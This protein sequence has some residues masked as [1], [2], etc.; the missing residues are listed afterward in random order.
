MI[1][2]T[3]CIFG[4]VAAFTAVFA[5]G[6]LEA[7]FVKAFNEGKPLTAERAFRQLTEKKAKLAPIRYW[8]AAEVARQTRKASLRRDRL[9]RFL[10]LEKTWTKETEQAAWELCVASADAREFARLAKNVPASPLLYRAGKLLLSRFR[11]EKRTSDFMSVAGTLLEKFTEKNKRLSV[12]GDLYHFKW[13]NAPGYSLK[14]S[15]DLLLKYPE[16]AGGEPVNTFINWRGKELDAKWIVDYS[17]KYKVRLPFNYI[18]NSMIPRLGEVKDAELRKKLIKDFIALEN[19]YLKGGE[20][21]DSLYLHSAEWFGC[22]Y[23]RYARY[24]GDG[25]SATAEQSKANVEFIKRFVKA[26]PATDA[27]R[28]VCQRVIGE[29]IAYKAVFPVDIVAYSRENPKVFSAVDLYN[30][31]GVLAE[32]S[33]QKSIKPLKDLLARADNRYPVRWNTLYLLAEYGET[34]IVKSTLEESISNDVLAPDVGAIFSSAVRCK[35]LSD[36]QKVEMVAGLYKL[37]GHGKRWEFLIGKGAEKAKKDYKFL[38]TPEGNAFLAT[39]K[40]TVVSS[41]PIYAALVKIA[42][43][44]QASGGVCPGE[45]HKVVADAIKAYIALADKAKSRTS[46][47]HAILYRYYTLCQREPNSA[48]KYIEVTKDIYGNGYGYWDGLNHMCGLAMRNAKNE[49]IVWAI[50]EKRA[51]VTGDYSPLLGCN[52]PSSIGALPKDI[53]YF[54]ANFD[55]FASFITRQFDY[56]RIKSEKDML[57]ALNLL[58]KHPGFR[59]PGDWLID[60]VSRHFSSR[61]SKPEVVKAFPWNEALA[62]IVDADVA[63]SGRAARVMLNMFAAVGRGDE[64]LKTYLAAANKLDSVPKAS[65]IF[66]LVGM[67]QIITFP[68]DK[69]AV[70]A[71]VKDRMGPFLRE[72]VIPALSAIKSN[73]FPLVDLG[74]AQSWDALCNYGNANRENKEVQK[75]LL[76]TYRQGVKL[77]NGNC[78][79]APPDSVYHCIAY[80]NVYAE[81]LA[82][83]NT[84]KM[85]EC[86]AT[87]G[88]TVWHWNYGAF[89]NLLAKTRDAGFWESAYLMAN[90]VPADRDSSTVAF[91]SRV[92]AEAAPK[93]PGIYPVDEKNPAYPLY[94]AAD[95]LSRKNSERAWELLKK[96]VAVFEREAINL[97][98]DFTA[99]GVEQLRLDRGAKDENLIKARQIAT[100]I[101]GNEARVIADLAAAMLLVRAECFR[102]Q[103]NFEAA[104]LEYQSIRNNPK[105]NTTPAGRKAM[106]R[107][108]DLMIETGN[109]S[110][111]EATIEYWLSQPDTEIQAQA[112]YFAAR[113]AFDRKD[114]DETIKELREVFAI[115][116]THTDARFLQGK[117]KLATNSEVDDTDVMIG[118]LSDRTAIRPGQ[119]LTITVQDRNLSVAGGGAS[120]PVIL[121]AKPGG[122]S[123][124]IL[125][126]PSSRD[127]NLFKGVVD[128]RLAEAFPSNL[129]L[130]VQGDDV[131]QYVIEPEFLKARGLPLNKPKVLRVI[132][133][134]KLSIGAGAPRAEEKDTQSA[135]EESLDGSLDMSAVSSALRPG[136]PLYVFVQDKDRSVGKDGVGELPVS[137][138]TTSGDNLENVTLKETK[139][140]SGIFRAQ[141]QTSLPPPR[142]FASDT[143]AGFNAG[144]VINKNKSGEWR[145]LADGQPGK[146]IEVD[147][148][149]SHRVSNATIRIKN[150]QEIRAVTLVGRLGTETIRL[151]SLPA[152]DVKKR[153]GI[154]YQIENGVRLRSADSIRARFGRVKGPKE[155]NVSNFTYSATHSGTRNSTMYWSAAFN[156]PNEYDYMRL[157]IVAKNTQGNTFRNLWIAMDLD[158]EQVFQGQGAS[159]HNR[160]VTFDV[161]AGTHRFELFASA[162]LKDDSFDILWEPVGEDARPLP[163]DWFDAA[164]NSSIVKFLEDK[165]VISRTDDG[166]AATFPKPVRLRSLRWEF[167][168]RTGP[169]VTVSKMTV[170]D[171]KGEAVIPCASDFSDA[172]RNDNLEVA[173]GDS[174]FVTYQDEITSSGE[175]RILQKNIRS[176]F[177]NAK[178]NFFFEQ[179]EVSKGGWERQRL[180]QAFRFQPGDVIIASVVDADGDLTPQADKIKAVITTK[181]GLRKEITLVEQSK[182]YEGISLNGNTL[183]GIHSGL[184]MALVK[185]A[186]ADDP[187]APANAIKVQP[188][189]MLT[190]AY[191][192]RENTNPG[193]PFVRTDR[194]QAA[195]KGEPH[196]TLFHTRRTRVVDNSSTAKAQLEK[197]RRRAGNE[198]V[199]ALY[200]DV[201]H[202]VPMT[203][204]I[205]ASKEPIPVNVSTP[206]PVR[207]NDPA[208]A[209][210]AASKIMLRASSGTESIEIPM[211]LGQRF[212]GFYLRKG[213]ESAK[214]AYAAGSFNTIVKLRMGPPDPNS[215]LAEDEDPELGVTGADSVKIEVLDEAGNPVI[216][217]TLKLVSNASLTLMDSTFTAPRDAAHVGEKFFIQVED[218]DRDASEATD[219][220]DVTAIGLVSGTTNTIRLTETLPHSGIFTGTYPSEK[221]GDQMIF[222]YRDDLTLPGT[223]AQT[224]CATGSVFRG[225][226]GSVRMF[227]KRFRDSDAAVLVQ[228]RLA[229]C[230]FEQAKEHRKLKQQERSAK[231]IDEGKYILEEALR[232]YPDSTHVAQGEFLLANLYQELATEKK[233]AKDIVG[234]TPL[235]TEA[236]ARFSAILSSW[237]DG[238]F[239]AR[240]QYH[241]ALCLEML[242]DYARASEEYVKMT[243]LYPESELVGDATIRLATYYYKEAKRYDISGKIYQ[244]FQKR[245]PTHEKAPRALFMSG[246]CYVKQ[247]E[248]AQKNFT[249]KHPAFKGM[250][251]ETVEMYRKAVVAFS[252][253]AEKYVETAPPAMR[254]QSLY[255]AGD[256]AL[257]VRDFEQSYLYLKR[258]VFEYPETEWARR[259]RG[260]LL[261]EAKSFEGLE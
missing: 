102:D 176:S 245:F 130:E 202:A 237:P 162:L 204:A 175:K 61:L 76:D 18:P 192:D 15:L 147:T 34:T 209:R 249:E 241:K 31:S 40:P 254:A 134:A 69:A 190:L 236:L 53:D 258:T 14:D 155:L 25:L 20:K 189:E 208:R 105:Y 103:Q 82:A 171:A 217:R 125:L 197:I 144:D 142:A 95:E 158:G 231:A 206:I 97:P 243:Y 136:N 239:A 207:V 164:K 140:Y 219:L 223:P 225:S 257:R 195:K 232:N 224:L 150:P 46:A 128:V 211:R 173:P 86:A 90:S 45:A 9:A 129:V 135:L 151:G 35:N 127:P 47:M 99:W 182:Y 210:H 72:H 74:D 8:Q 96:N 64:A 121:T 170:T 226:D 79:G 26:I 251:R 194:V 123:E 141:I 120:I 65:R 193:V 227:S 183:D 101:L 234:A 259:A 255:W 42:S 50:N 22:F 201:L 213:A 199:K 122:D 30:L 184:F 27:G 3:L 244:N 92:R 68:R 186:A 55:V 59:I 84:F 153:I 118:D 104:K 163:Y 233:D 205:S 196:V 62:K 143:A 12:A 10:A 43:L 63:N 247:A 216:S 203:S 242:G 75:T 131:A 81:S 13:E 93:L 37:T 132:D 187:K 111:A 80:Q 198:N 229:E 33:K 38:N 106:F 85:A 114:Y 115:D 235:Y 154:K 28:S 21:P 6:D 221:Y 41:D 138:R 161:P 48:A 23:A 160:I 2:K 36:K 87:F 133:D 159:L 5:E 166:F 252:D 77:M 240:S 165:A 188:D 67:Y 39:I 17:T 58:F 156:Q 256:A 24:L 169:D 214:E 7:T 228:F 51:K 108:V 119:Q 191:E 44:K 200:R 91:A 230:L 94:V 16:L 238:A 116:F 248:V 260:L 70:E 218:A 29:F 113:I 126:Y 261:Q 178:V 52:I 250:C 174:I 124:R 54:K 152:E 212:P 117:W 145:S 57:E 32:V 149:A 253:V 137:V 167:A 88:A 185:T 66:A 139:P 78:R 109:T 71:G 107:A 11:S 222:S 179:T 148:M 73:E 83:S 89:K 60:N 110:G 112:H 157:R 49:G 168:D 19:V 56:G 100:A 98:P 246:S 177:N 220:V 146:W 180:Y 172:Q 4:S 215:A 1:K 181:S